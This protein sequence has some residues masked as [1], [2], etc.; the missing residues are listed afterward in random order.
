MLNAVFENF[1][2]ELIDN[3]DE[4]NITSYKKSLATKKVLV[5]D[6]YDRMDKWPGKLSE[7]VEYVIIESDHSFTNKRDE[8][9]R[10]IINW[11]GSN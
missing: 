2:Q 1:A 10:F 6:D 4:Y 7:A 5:L 9:S 3:R 11:L 8:L